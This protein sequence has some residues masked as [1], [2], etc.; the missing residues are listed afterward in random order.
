MNN[1]ETCS[2]QRNARHSHFLIRSTSS[3]GFATTQTAI[4]S[5]I[6]PLQIHIEEGHKFNIHACPNNY[7]I[8]PI[9]SFQVIL[10]LWNKMLINIKIPDGKR[11]FTVLMLACSYMTNH[12]T[13]NLEIQQQPQNWHHD[14]SS[15]DISS[16]TLRLQTFRLQIFRLLWLSFLK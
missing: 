7:H 5:H 8:C 16:T 14:N 6:D 3:F 12:K 2:L 10:E 15:T 13:G 1:F 11:I 4:L 9:F